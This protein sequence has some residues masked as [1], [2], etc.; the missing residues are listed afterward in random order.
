MNYSLLMAI[1]AT[2]LSSCSKDA[3]EYD[4]KYMPEKNQTNDA[5]SEQ[6][7]DYT[8]YKNDFETSSLVP[9]REGWAWEPSYIKMIDGYCEFYYNQ[10]ACTNDNRR[11]RRGCELVCEF[12]TD[13]EGWYGY[14]LF[15][16]EDKMPKDLKGTIITQIFQQGRRNCWA[17][18]LD[19]DG[20]NLT[21]SFRH[22]LIDPNVKTIGK[23]KWGKWQDIIVYFRAGTNKKGCIKVWLGSELKESNP[24]LVCDNINLG[25]A[26]N[27][28][29][30]THQDDTPYQY[31]GSTYIDRIGGKWGFY[32]EEGGDRTLRIDNLRILEGNPSGA[33]DIVNP[34]K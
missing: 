7:I 12:K 17:G 23:L 1:L 20:E 28:I 25:F 30:D 29:D 32:V 26:E 13:S 8:L 14:K 2:M 33:F 5:N 22:A 24:T 15:L 16:P 9:F 31:N 4:D 19:I 3:I 10:E 11:E 21:I 34:S 18:H 27:W 6:T